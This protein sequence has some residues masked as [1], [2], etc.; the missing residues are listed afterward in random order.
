MKLTQDEEAI[1]VQEIRAGLFKPPVVMFIDR[2][3]LN[4]MKTSKLRALVSLGIVSVE[5]VESL[6]ATAVA[7]PP[8]RAQRPAAVVSGAGDY[9]TGNAENHVLRTTAT[10]VA[11]AGYVSTPSIAGPHVL[12]DITFSEDV[13]SALT[14]NH[15]IYADVKYSSSPITTDAAWASAKSVFDSASGLV[16]PL[17]AVVP[18]WLFS[19]SGNGKSE[20]HLDTFINES[21]V[22]Y[23][24]KCQSSAGLANNVSAYLS[25]RPAV[26]ARAIADRV[27]LPSP[28]AHLTVPPTG[29]AL[30]AITRFSGAPVVSV[31]KS[32]TGEYVAWTGRDTGFI[33]PEVQMSNFAAQWRPIAIVPRNEASARSNALF[34]AGLI[35]IPGAWTAFPAYKKVVVTFAPTIRA[36]ILRG[37]TAAPALAVPYLGGLSASALEPEIVIA[38]GEV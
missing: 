11:D 13:E 38:S 1:I 35:S 21:L 2:A 7:L 3:A 29:S 8:P 12:T 24:L 15:S 14:T 25:I 5:R 31:V 20:H 16:A 18:V 34:M 23:T 6:A 9:V 27:K 30:T 10:F 26:G 37:G 4:S 33:V 19:P 36:P 17:L 28:V 32:T 22:Y